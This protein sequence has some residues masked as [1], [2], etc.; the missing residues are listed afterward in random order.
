MKRELKKEAVSNYKIKYKALGQKKPK[1][2]DDI[3]TIC[4]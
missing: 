2:V 1:S 4:T 3:P